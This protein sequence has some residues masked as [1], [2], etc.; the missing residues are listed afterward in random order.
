[1]LISAETGTRAETRLKRTTEM[2]EEMLRVMRENTAND[3]EL[4]E[5]ITQ[6]TYGDENPDNLLP[7]NTSILISNGKVNHKKFLKL[8][9]KLQQNLEQR[10]VVEPWMTRIKECSTYNAYAELKHTLN[11]YVEGTF[12]GE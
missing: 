9:D 1:M 10:K 12:F 6:N 11:Q 3:D 4:I 7:E 5:M 8:L 2:V